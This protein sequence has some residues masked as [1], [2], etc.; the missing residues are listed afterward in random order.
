MSTEL[1]LSAHVKSPHATFTHLLQ[2][3][4]L[5]QLTRRTGTAQPGFEAGSVTPGPWSVP[6]WSVPD[7]LSGRPIHVRGG[8]A[9]QP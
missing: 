2:S 8:V 5:P 4:D 7:A 9:R 1:L 6:R 3:E